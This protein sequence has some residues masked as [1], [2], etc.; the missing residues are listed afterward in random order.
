MP[1][2]RSRLTCSTMRPPSGGDTGG[3][4]I[5]GRPRLATRSA[6]PWR[7]ERGRRRGSRCS[8][9]PGARRRTH[10]SG[11]RTAGSRGSRARRAAPVRA[12]GRRAR[13]G[14]SEG[15][16]PSPRDGV[17]ARRG[18]IRRTVASSVCV[19][20]FAATVSRSTPRSATCSSNCSRYH[21]YVDAMPSVEVDR[22]RPAE[23]AEPR[24]VEQLA[25]R[26]VG[27]GRVPHDRR[28][29]D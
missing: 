28:R 16:H 17:H 8:G 2:V 26:A 29:R 20:A 22:R 5:A 10:S 14:R 3:A 25:G 1:I 12:P 13:A 4:R 23:V 21:S 27:L 15:R 11:V 7:S 6:R 19:T 18:S 24:D 9:R